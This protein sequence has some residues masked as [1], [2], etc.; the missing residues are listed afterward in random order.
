MFAPEGSAGTGLLI[1]IPTVGFFRSFSSSLSKGFEDDC[2]DGD[3]VGPFPD[4]VPDR[5]NFGPSPSL[6]NTSTALSTL[7]FSP[8]KTVAFRF[9]SMKPRSRKASTFS[10]IV[11]PLS[12]VRLPRGGL[13]FLYELVSWRGAILWLEECR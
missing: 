10:S 9:S 3:D 11:S 7:P 12:S 5:E 1:V 6:I 8:L 4:F 13:S 2:V